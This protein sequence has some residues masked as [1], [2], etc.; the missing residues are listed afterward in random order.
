MI[1]NTQQFKDLVRNRSHGDSAK[2][3]AIIR[4]YMMERFLE[5]LSLSYYRDN[6]ILKGGVLVSAMVGLDNRTTMDIDTA[7]KGLP[8][9]EED[10][11]RITEDII[12]VHLDDAVS[13][14]VTDIATIMDEAD[15]PGVRV[16]MVGVF[17]EMRTP[18]KVDFSTDDVITPREISYPFKLLFEERS[19][20]LLAY[21]VSTILAEKLETVLSRGIANTRMRDFYDIYAFLNTQTNIDHDEVK[22]AFENTVAKRG[23][24][25]V[26]ADA[27]TILD[28]L[29][30]DIGLMNLWAA[31][32]RKFDYAANVSWNDVMRTV[33][34]LR[35]WV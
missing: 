28:E 1:R 8:L 18:F 5:R 23:A 34:E 3:Q 11:R 17:E 15:Y 16:M 30:A 10:V 31:Y 25:A 32:Q 27:D 7:I 12:A 4:A 29:A 2:A 14:E 24:Q 6:L 22:A 20:S 35:S 33:K 21:N 26:A 9:S 19:I 13:F